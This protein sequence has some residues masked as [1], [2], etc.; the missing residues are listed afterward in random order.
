MPNVWSTI[1]QQ[2]YECFN[3]PRTI[4]YEFEKKV[5]ELKLAKERML[6]I[7]TTILSFPQR[8][9][10]I[11]A[12][13]LDIF[14]SFS[15]PFEK[16]K[17]FYGFIDDVCN[18]HKAL[19]K[20]YVTCKEK[21]E[22]IGMDIACWDAAFQEVENNLKQREENRKVYDHY[23]EKMSKMVKERNEKFAKGRAETE[24]E[25]ESF[26][27]N[28]EK[29]KNAAT[30][31]ISIS[32]NTYYKI[33]ELLDKRYN[34]MIPVVADF[35]EAERVFYTHAASIFKYFENAKPKLQQM[36]YSFQ[37]TPVSYNASDYLRGRHILGKDFDPKLFTEKGIIVGS[38]KKKDPKEEQNEKSNNQNQNQNQNYNTNPLPSRQQT[39]AQGGNPY[40]NSN[41][42]RNQSV[43]NPYSVNP[44]A[45][46]Q[47]PRPNMNYNPSMGNQGGMASSVAASTRTQNPYSNEDIPKDNPLYQQGQQNQNQQSNLPNY[48]QPQNENN[49]FDQVKNPY[50][51]DFD[52]PDTGSK[53][54][55]NAFPPG[56]Q[57]QPKA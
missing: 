51:D 39:Y 35:I 27:R 37:K 4:D 3:G 31:F 18:A 14:N 42:Y 57:D 46:N 10:G 7:R 29:F 44:Y 45:N 48:N 5:Q 50:E 20:A 16:D 23:D 17:C 32:N 11:Q 47:G 2:A 22:K 55:S 41:I 1:L 36:G 52:F 6:Q 12:I 38:K 53:P 9:G 33:Q 34:M 19:E 54:N 8:T 24:K 40:N 30:E 43:V 15:L 25:I 49:N 21:I 28:E 13:C 56:D 26:E